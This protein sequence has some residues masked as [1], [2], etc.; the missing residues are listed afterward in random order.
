MAKRG[1][2]IEPLTDEQ[3]RA[4]FPPCP[5]RHH[6]NPPVRTRL[7][8]TDGRVRYVCYFCDYELDGEVIDGIERF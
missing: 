5:S 4:M 8:M 2:K 1:G 3:L 7:T 6:P